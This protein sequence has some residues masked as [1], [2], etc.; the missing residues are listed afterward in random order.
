MSD[1]AWG[2]VIGWNSYEPS[3]TKVTVRVRS[4]NDKINWSVWEDA[5]N[6]VALKLTPHGRYLEVEVCLERLSGTLSPLVYDVTISTLK[7]ESATA[8]AVSITGDKNVLNLGDNVKLTITAQNNG[9]HSA[10]VKVN[11]KIP[12]D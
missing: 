9:P 11:H 3:G 6:G 4:S 2:G 12:L 7:G 10:D 1:N 8:L 5:V